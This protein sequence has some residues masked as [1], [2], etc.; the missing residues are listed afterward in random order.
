MNSLEVQILHAIELLLFF[1][2][3]CFHYLSKPSRFIST[4]PGN[5]SWRASYCA[6]NTCTQKRSPCFLLISKCSVIWEKDAWVVNLKLNLEHWTN[7]QVEIF[8]S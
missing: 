8:I 7:F 6:T 2:L 3:C 1:P 5:A 4:S